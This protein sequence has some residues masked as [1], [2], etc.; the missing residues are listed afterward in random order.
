[1]TSN[2]KTSNFGTTSDFST[3]YILD[4]GEFRETKLE[5]LFVIASLKETWFEVKDT[6][7]LTSLPHNCSTK[8]MV[9]SLYGIVWTT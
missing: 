2:L 5:G 9:D 8:V 6:P 1:L 3:I 4:R 7:G